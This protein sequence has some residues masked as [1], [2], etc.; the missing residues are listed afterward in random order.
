MPSKDILSFRPVRDHR[1]DVGRILD[2]VAG[3]HYIWAEI[4]ISMSSIREG[5]DKGRR[6]N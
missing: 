1:N 4:Q 2:Y 3:K 6:A 5:R